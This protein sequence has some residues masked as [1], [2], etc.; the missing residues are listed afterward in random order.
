MCGCLS[1]GPHCG[2]GPQPR[3]V[4]WL[5][6]KPVTLWFTACTQSTELLQSGIQQS[7]KQEAI[8]GRRVA[9]L[10]EVGIKVLLYADIYIPFCLLNSCLF[11]LCSCSVSW[12]L[13][14]GTVLL[15]DLEEGCSLVSLTLSPGPDATRVKI[16]CIHSGKIVTSNEEF[17]K[18]I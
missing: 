10:S 18:V 3:R 16:I 17:W 8:L 4:P 12:W 6:I 1:R 15:R 14:E 7:F 13:T 2:P 5:G 11:V 9:L